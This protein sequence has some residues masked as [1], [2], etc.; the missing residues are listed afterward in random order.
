MKTIKLTGNVLILIIILFTSCIALRKKNLVK[1]LKNVEP[2]PKVFCVTLKTKIED[3]LYVKAKIGDRA[4]EQKFL[5]DTGSPLTYSFKTKDSFNLKTKKYFRFGSKKAAYGSGSITLGNV[6]FN[7]AGFIVLQGD[8][9][10]EM[11]DLEGLIGS[12]ILQ[13]SICELNFEDSTIKISNDLSNFTNIQN[14]Y[15]SDFE[16]S[17]AQ[18]T[19]V[20]KIAIGKDTVTAFIDTGF[21]GII[22]LSQKEKISIDAASKEE[23]FSNG[24]YFGGPDKDHFFYRTY[25]QVHQMRISG[26]KMD[27]I[28]IM[29]YPEYYGRN[30]VGLGFLKKFIITIDWIHHRIYFKPIE[31]INFKKNIYTYGFTCLMQN[32]QLRVCNIYKGSEFEKAGIKS[33]DIIVS[34]N[35]KKDF[36]DAIISTINSNKPG[37]DSIQIEIKNKQTLTLKKNALFKINYLR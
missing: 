19:P 26:M 30:L 11:K 17:E 29:Q 6:K 13:T 23:S 37:N 36:S 21:D 18:G 25:Y 2:D 14:I 8:I 5:F 12:S 1:Q 24:R 27:S 9:M 20:V 35:K 33:G 34:I 4:E 28:V 16:P 22:K 32:K 31:E 7:N 15:S 10:E 3:Y